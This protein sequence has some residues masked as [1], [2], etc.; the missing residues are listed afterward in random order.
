VQHQKFSTFIAT[1]SDISTSTYNTSSSGS[2]Q[3]TYP[4]KKIEKSNSSRER[5]N[6]K[7]TGLNPVVVLMVSREV[8]STLGQKT[9]SYAEEARLRRRSQ[10]QS[11]VWPE[12]EL[13]PTKAA[14]KVK[15]SPRWIH[16][17]LHDL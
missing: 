7:L 9:V 2:T 12:K 15:A 1:Y 8:S 13:S 16:A 3:P 5:R 4:D 17:L 6:E 14:P 10:G 11:F